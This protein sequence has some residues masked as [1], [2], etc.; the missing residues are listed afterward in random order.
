MKE[1]Q[2]NTETKDQRLKRTFYTTRIISTNGVKSCLLSLLIM[3]LSLLLWQET[4]A[5]WSRYVG[6]ASLVM[7]FASILV[8]W[9]SESANQIVQHRAR[10]SGKGPDFFKEC[11][12][13]SPF[14]QI[15][16]HFSVGQ[17]VK[18]TKIIRPRSHVRSNHRAPRP[19]F[20]CASHSSRGNDDDSGSSGDPDSGNPSE[21]LRL[22]PAPQKP[23]VAAAFQSNNIFTFRGVPRL[24]AHVLAMGR[25]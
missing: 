10:K 20:A 9:V 1:K 17:R 8:G 5:E 23:S 15:V 12:C 14:R 21:Q 18:P 22:S 19:A 6:L 7:A 11:Q 24:M 4:R 13:P 2:N 16:S 3:V 25:G